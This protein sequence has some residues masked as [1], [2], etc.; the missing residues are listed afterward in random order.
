MSQRTCLNSWLA[1]LNQYGEYKVQVPFFMTQKAAYHGSAWIR[2]ATPYAGSD[3][4][5]HFPL[6]KG[7]EVLLSFVNGDPDQPVIMGAVPN[8]INPNVVTNANQKQSRI[9]T[10]GGNEITLHDEEGKQHMLL[11]TPSG[12]TWMRMGSRGFDPAASSYSY[13][14][15]ARP[16]MAQQWQAPPPKAQW[17]GVQQMWQG[18]ELPVNPSRQQQQNTSTPMSTQDNVYNTSGSEGFEINTD[19]S[20]GLSAGG[21]VQISADVTNV[22]SVQAPSNTT[23]ITFT[24]NSGN[25]NLSTK[26]LPGLMND[27]TGLYE[28]LEGYIASSSQWGKDILDIASF[29]PYIGTIIGSAFQPENNINI[30][31]GGGHYVYSTKYVNF[32]SGSAD[33]IN[34]SSDNTRSLYGISDQALQIT[35]QAVFNTDTY[36]YQI[37]L[38]SAALKSAN[39]VLSNISSSIKKKIAEI[40]NSGTELTSIDLKAN[41]TGVELVELGSKIESAETKVNSV[42]TKIESN[43]AD[44][45]SSS[46]VI[47]SNKIKCVNGLHLFTAG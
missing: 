29:V 19:E 32:C 34:L 47:Q 24:A 17:M 38:V 7:T 10:A 16:G 42:T 6:L 20:F 44:I 1:E 27:I 25:I 23:G 12:N 30:Y 9:R 35:H 13:T 5:M 26:S 31:S 40:K 14:S 4:G 22:D 46:A 43:D 39:V 3:H 11:K 15:R 8:S 21:G 28:D 36:A 37:S 18:G 33:K 41:D 2:M 45:S